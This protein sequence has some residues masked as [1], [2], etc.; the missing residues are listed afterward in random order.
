M[1][2]P[3]LFTRP[4]LLSRS[5][6]A[7]IIGVVALLAVSLAACGTADSDTPGQADSS[8]CVQDYREGVDYFEEK[9]SVEDAENFSIEYHDSYQVLTVEQPFPG[10]APESYV[11]VRCGT[12]PPELSGDLADAPT[13]TVPISSLYSAS[14]THLP[15]LTEL[16][17]LEVLTGVADASM[18]S[19][20]GVVKAL[21]DG[22]IAEYAAGGT[23][24]AEQVVIGDPD[25]LMTGGTDQPEYTKLRKSGTAVVANAEW[26][27]TTPL[28][29]A[30]WI[31]VM[32]AL[33]GREA[34]A[35]EVYAGIKERYQNVAA[36]AAEAK[37]VAVLI[38][39]DSDGTWYVPAGGSY[40]GRLVLDAGGTYPWADNLSTG[41]LELD[42]EAVYAKSAQ[43]RTWLVNDTDLES[44][45]DLLA[46]DARYAE[47]AA[48]RS[49]A[50][51]NAT[52]ALGPNGGNDYWE[53]GV[54]R[55]DLVL[56]DLVKILHPDLLPEHEFEFYQ[57]L[58]TP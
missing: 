22:E 26:L 17:A 32:G 24:D 48:S 46:R 56:A 20:P 7:P 43:A 6:P 3:S 33:T 25:V 23:L 28:G 11:L 53:R 57:K 49:G 21:Q 37:P 16:G 54:L 18:V 5:N 8:A 30:E 50:V 47:F 10:G 12:P 19:D 58:T 40:T 9:S 29:R 42:F 35:Q 14:T 4:T 2:I 55:P 52:A 1:R 27:E 15:L 38:G 41:S 39:T 31:K 45:Q 44:M 34:K 13:L 51:W 36:G